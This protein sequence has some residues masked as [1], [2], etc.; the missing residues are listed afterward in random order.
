[1]QPPRGWLVVILSLTVAGA[2]CDEEPDADELPPPET[3]RSSV[4]EAS[5]DRMAEVRLSSSAEAAPAEAASGVAEV[6][7]AE[8]GESGAARPTSRAELRPD[9]VVDADPDHGVTF[10]VLYRLA[11]AIGLPRPQIHGR[12]TA[13]GDG[14]HVALVSFASAAVEGVAV[15]YLRPEIWLV[16][17]ERDGRTRRIGALPIEHVPAT[18]YLALSVGEVREQAGEL[19]HV[20]STRAGDL[21]E[22]GKTEFELVVEVGDSVV[23]GPGLLV[24]RYYMIFNLDPD[25]RLAADVPL[26][27]QSVSGPMSRATVRLVDHDADGH[28]DIHLRTKHCTDGDYGDYEHGEPCRAEAT[29]H[30][31]FL[32]DEGTDRW[33]RSSNSDSPCPEEEH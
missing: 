7:P 14:R 19:F 4:E 30:T 28:P 5:P 33:S 23:C 9:A 6:P 27:E 32:W 18:D 13:V 31:Y 12:P 25:L 1:M 21:D 20:R 22:D 8:G 3:E 29:T 10:A 26:A 17:Q 11:A 24:H 15:A 16:Q 2:G